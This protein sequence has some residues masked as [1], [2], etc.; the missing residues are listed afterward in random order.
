LK[1]SKA[2]VWLRNDLR[3]RDNAALMAGCQHEHLTIVYILEDT[4]EWPMGGASLWW[5][6]HSLSALKDDLND[7]KQ[8][9]L[10]YRGN[11][12]S[13]I[14][15][16]VSEQ[17]FA[18]VYWNRRYEKHQIDCDAAIKSALKDLGVQCESF[19]GNLLN[20]PWEVL[21]KDKTPYQVY[22]PYWRAKLLVPGHPINHEAP[23]K[24]PPPAVKST[25]DSCNLDDL[26]LLPQIP[27]DKAMRDQWQ[28]GE[29]N[30]LKRLKYVLEHIVLDYET[31]RN[32]PD[33]DG[34][35]KLSPHLHFGEISPQRIWDEVIAVHGPASKVKN[36]NIEQ[37]LK[38]IVWREFAAHLLFH[39]PK[40]DK[41]PL[42]EKFLKFPWEDRPTD[43][44]AWCKGRTGY[45]IIDAGMR[46]LWQHGWMHNRVRMIVGSFLVKDLRVHWYEG[47]KWFWDTLLDADL[48]SNSMGW[49]WAAGC[50]ADAAP[51]F[52]V[53][54][55]S[56][57]SK[58]FDPEGHYIRTFVPEL[59]RMPNEWI[60]EPWE[61]PADVLKRAGVTLGET[62]PKPLV[63]HFEEK[64]LALKAYDRL[65]TV[66]V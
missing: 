3:L 66:G 63:D 52:R 53:F 26:N 32:I 39:F 40:T 4:K 16:L 48:A 47:A 14:K 31:Q 57:Q 20:E 49:Q 59:K 33:T 12:E 35:S 7:R 9:L 18:A 25:K 13:C 34:T 61:A 6:H 17:G 58:K 23:K 64:L 29:K 2:L 30:A 28:P 41:E 42:R 22:T 44:H 11:A 15:K 19:K 24:L 46:Q 54:N 50:G 43:F 1:K 51:Y 45:P 65:K 55:P 38:E 60:H 27:W 36:K 10:F 8:D 37:F 21:K 62:Y 56:L 5:L